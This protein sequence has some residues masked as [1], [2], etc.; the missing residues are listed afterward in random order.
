MDFHRIAAKFFFQQG[1]SKFE[2]WSEFRRTG[3]PKQFPM[4]VNYSN[5]TIDSEIKIRRL[6]FTTNEY[7][8]NKAEV[9]KAIQL[10]GGPDNGGTKLW[11]DTNAGESNF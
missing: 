2:A 1:N 9:D 7:R 8:D 6:P 3:Y 4:V 10:L 11:W 5:G